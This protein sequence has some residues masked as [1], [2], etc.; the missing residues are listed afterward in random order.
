MTPKTLTDVDKIWGKVR[1]ARRNG[2]AYT[3]EE[4]LIG[5]V[6]LAAAVVGKGGRPLGA[7]HIAGSRSSSKSPR[8]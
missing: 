4:A 8:S 2:Y 1:E 5:E 3:A 6:V 7:V